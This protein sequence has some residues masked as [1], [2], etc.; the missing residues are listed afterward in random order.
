MSKDLTEAI[1]SLHQEVTE[2]RNEQNEFRVNITKYV[3][4]MSRDTE[5]MREKI[6]NIDTKF[7]K[8]GFCKNPEESNIIKKTI[9][10]LKDEQNKVKW[11]AI[12][13]AAI[14]SIIITGAMW[15][16]QNKNNILP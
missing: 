5:W 2:L 15:I 14:L 4:S 16:I 6:D 10:D 7:D 1:E 8:C 9:Q 13:A 12:G 3:T 11:T